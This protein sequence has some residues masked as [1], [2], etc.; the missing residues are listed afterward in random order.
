MVLLPPPPHLS[1]GCHDV[2][3]R[4]LWPRRR[5]GNLCLG[6]SLALP[7]EWFPLHGLFSGVFHLR[8]FMRKWHGLLLVHLQVSTTSVLLLLRMWAWLYFA[9][10]PV[11]SSGG[12]CSYGSSTNK[13]PSLA[14]RR[15]ETE[16]WLHMTATVP[17]ECERR[18]EMACWVAVDY[19][20]T[21]QLTSLHDFVGI[22]FYVFQP[23]WLG[24][25]LSTN[26]SRSLAVIRNSQNHGYIRNQRTVYNSLK[27]RSI[28]I[29]QSLS[30]V[31]DEA[32]AKCHHFAQ[33][34][35]MLLI[36][37]D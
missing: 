6:L 28:L 3:L 25:R 8:T 22:C 4:L 9:S 29:P 1:S 18:F 11:L 14:V 36:L 32:Y 19:V 10:D 23:I 37:G 5:L 20:A 17:S 33:N 26:I 24:L 21:A 15:N 2:L 13:A 7:P 35:Q 12:F 31:M 34:M 30:A 27:V 16:Y